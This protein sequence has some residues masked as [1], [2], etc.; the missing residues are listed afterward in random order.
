[1][2]EQT[3]AAVTLRNET[4]YT[5]IDREVLIAQR[6]DSSIWQCRFLIDKK[7]Q[8]TSTGE[9]DFDKAKEKAKELFYKAQARKDAD[10][11]PITR[12]FKDV[13]KVVLKQLHKDFVTGKNK[14]TYKDY[15]QVIERYLIPILGKYN[16]DSINYEVLEEL[17][18]KRTAKMGKAPTKSTLM[19]HNAALNRIFDEAIYRGYMP[20]SKKPEL[21]AKGT[22]YVRREEFTID[23]VIKLRSNYDQFIQKGRVDSQDLRALMCDYIEIL[24]DTG[25]RPGNE[26]L[27]LKWHQVT[28]KL[29]PVAT[30]TG[31]V[32]ETNED[33]NDNEE[34]VTIDA[35]SSAFLHIKTGKTGERI[36]AGRAETVQ[37]LRRIA[38]NNFDLSL[39][40]AIAQKANELVFL[41]KEFISKKRGNLGT[42]TVL[43]QPTSFRRLFDTY[44]DELGLLFTVGGKKRQL[45][46]LRHTYATMM[47]VHDAVSPH[48][49]AKQMG[50][51]VAMIERH[52]SHLD[53][54]KAVHQLRGDESRQLIRPVYAWQP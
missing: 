42:T 16:V 12:K 5:V 9:R 21:K 6:N 47:L 48:T 1:M 20:A 39:K 15:T 23:E 44:L 31:E 22:K 34:D 52:Y 13:A 26:L 53:S 45:Y 7:W 29:Y 40:D 4:T 54:V 27:D 24:L 50:T 19:T 18:V 32:I 10:Y 51:S 37:A 35:N 3:G 8:R 41:S 30:K 11:A 46:S 49:L 28:T 17:E 14:T 33:G 38:K 36:A 43:L 25:A 2:L